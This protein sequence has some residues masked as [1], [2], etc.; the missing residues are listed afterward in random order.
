MQKE[1]GE[2]EVEAE[3]PMTIFLYALR[4]PET[5]RQYPKRLKVFLDYLRLGGNLQE[6]AKQFLTK[7]KQNPQWAQYSLM[8]FIS[9]Q[10][11]RAGLGHI[12]RCK[13]LQSNQIVY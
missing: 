3:D 10:K 7:A 5:K 8:Q 6:Q 4:A 11:E 2:S 1:N 12:I 9:F 13:L